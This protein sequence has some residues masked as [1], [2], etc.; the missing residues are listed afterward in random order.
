[1]I[2]KEI[3]LYS[4]CTGC[5]SCMNKCP[6]NCI[7]MEPNLE[8]F[9]YPKIDSSVCVKCKKCLSSC[10]ILHDIVI[11]NMPTAFACINKNEEIRLASSSGGVFSLVADY[12]INKGGTVF[13]ASF[14]ENFE[15]EHNYVKCTDGLAKLRGSKYLQ[16]KIGISYTQVKEFLDSGKLVLFTGTPCQ[17]A[18]LKAFLGDY[19]YDNLV[20]VD[21]ICHGVPSPE[22]WRKYIA[23]RESRA[24]AAPQYISF[25]HKEKG[26]KKFS[27]RFS[28]KNNTN[29]CKIFC[30]DIFMKIFLRDI[31]LRSSCYNC[32][33]K[34][35]NR[36]SDITLADFWGVEGLLPDMDDDK[37]TSLLF[38]NSDIGKDVFNSISNSMK[39]KAVDISEAVA[40]NSAAIK[41]APQNSNRENF[42]VD[43]QKLNFEQLDR[44]YCR[45]KL[46]VRIKNRGKLV[47]RNLFATIQKLS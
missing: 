30:E 33:Y 42:F 10:P 28:F 12:V 4:E 7:S 37:G 3:D 44:K 36:Q 20:T 45:N 27:V 24:E 46:H 21:I 15:L 18:G 40:F 11:D 1:M 6:R 9:L 5:H 17:I 47:I 39:Y 23:Y 41:S 29:Y 25:R 31:C 38:I 14:N 34:T 32:K 22:V 2:D 35:L 43:L 19:K 16:S 8:G 26:W 13:G